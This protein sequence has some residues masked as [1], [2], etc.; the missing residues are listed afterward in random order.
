MGAIKEGVRRCYNQ[1]LSK[2][3]KNRIESS[4]E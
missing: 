2:K 4:M 1:I 3:E